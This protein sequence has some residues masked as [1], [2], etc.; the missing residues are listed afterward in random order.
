MDEIDLR[1]PPQNV[2]AFA[3]RT[4]DLYVAFIKEGFPPEDARQMLAVPI[5][6]YLHGFKLEEGE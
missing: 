4:R 6:M 2:R 3:A 5:T 1:E